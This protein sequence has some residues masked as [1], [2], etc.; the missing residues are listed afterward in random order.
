MTGTCIL[1]GMTGESEASVTPILCR[2]G[3]QAVSIEAAGD[4]D[5]LAAAGDL[6]VVIFDVERPGTEALSDFRQIRASRSGVVVFGWTLTGAIDGMAERLTR[7]RATGAHSIVGT[8]SLDME[9]TV[10]EERGFGTPAFQRRVLIIED[11]STVRRILSGYVED[12]GYLPVARGDWESAISDP[13]TFGVDIVVTDIF[14]PGMGG[15]AGIVAVKRDWLETPVIALSAGL[16]GRMGS[17]TVLK[18]SKTIGADVTLQKPISKD[19]LVQAIASLV[20]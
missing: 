10:F 16:G 12:A 15:I 11:D 2:H 19:T 6:K 14:M 3:L 9:L 4:G 13:E 17:E 8:A 7:L 20:A 18:A 5:I 1:V